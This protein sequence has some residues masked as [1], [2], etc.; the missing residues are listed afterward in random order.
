M[1]EEVFQQLEFAKHS[2]FINEIKPQQDISVNCKE[3]GLFLTNQTN[4]NQHLQEVHKMSNEE[5]AGVKKKSKSGI[6]PR[7]FKCSDCDE[8]FKR[9]SNMIRHKDR[10]HEGKTYGCGVC[11]HVCGYRSGV[12]GHCIAKGHDKNLIYMIVDFPWNV[13][14]FLIFSLNKAS[15]F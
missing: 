5:S 1:W 12:L 13:C 4:L 9:S 11:G 14:G 8:T 3:C 10:F 2:D 15:C 6:S 7:R